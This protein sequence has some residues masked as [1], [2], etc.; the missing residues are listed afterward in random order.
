MTVKLYD[1]DSHLQKFTATIVSCE[2][3]SS[4][5]VVVLDRTAF[6]PEAGGQSADTGFLNGVKVYDVQIDDEIIYHY[7]TSPLTKGETVTGVID[8]ERRF[9]FMQQHSAEHIVSGVAHKL[10]GCENVGFHL[11]DD[12]VTLDFD[13][14]LSNEQL[15]KLEELSNKAVFDNKKFTTY[16][17]DDDTLKNLSYRSKKQLDGAIRIVE[18]EDTDMCACCAPHVNF[19]G[20]IGIIKLLGTEKLRGGIRI[21]MRAGS[22]ALADYNCKYKNVLKISNMLCVKQNEAADAVQKLTEQIV[23]LKYQLNGFKKQAIDNKINNFKPLS[24]ITAC[25]EEE[26]EMKDIQMYADTLFKK[27]GGIRAAF[28]KKEDNGFAFA[29]C[30]EADKLNVFFTE[31]KAKFTVKGGGRGT[32]VQGTVTATENEIINFFN[33]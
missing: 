10:Y 22:R 11:S 12:I 23:D 5:Y 24:D 33:G 15:A 13:K 29:I 16:Y 9:D 7:T 25:F 17:P 32:M 27:F 6:F 18:I 26:L 30:G 31:F 14:V 20:E 8:W 21:E 3:I 4:N 19:A 28:S 1:E 2:E